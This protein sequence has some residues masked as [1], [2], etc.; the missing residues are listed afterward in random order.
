MNCLSLIIALFT[1][2]P[3][4]APNRTPNQT[5]EA[6]LL[7]DG[8]TG[9]ATIHGSDKEVKVVGLRRD[10]QQRDLADLNLSLIHI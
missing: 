10:G 5:I 9:P 2:I 1:L 3:A 7:D 4:I 8:Q 6:S